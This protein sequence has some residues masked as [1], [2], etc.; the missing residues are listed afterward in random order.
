MKFYFIAVLLCLAFVPTL[1]SAD[2]YAEDFDAVTGGDWSQT[3]FDTFSGSQDGIIGSSVC[4]T[5]PNCVGADG[6]ESYAGLQVEVIQQGLMSAFLRRNNTSGATM[7]FGYSESIGLGNTLMSMYI[8]SGEHLVLVATGV[9]T[10]DLGLTTADE[11][12]SVVLKWRNNGSVYEVQGTILGGSLATTTPWYTTSIDP[13]SIGTSTYAWIRHGSSFGTSGYLDNFFLNTEFEEPEEQTF[14]T[15]DSPVEGG[16]TD[17]R[18][19]D[20]DFTYTLDSRIAGAEE[21][22]YIKFTLCSQFYINEECVTE[23]YPTSFGVDN[24][25]TIEMESEWDGYSL[26][27]ASFWNGVTEDVTCPWWN[28]ICQEEQVLIGPTDTINLN[29]A[30]T[31]IDAD[32]PEW[33]LNGDLCGSL[34]SDIGN[35]FCQALAFLFYPSDIASE[36]MEEIRSIMAQKQPFGFFFLVSERMDELFQ[37]EGSAGSGL[38]IN[39]GEDWGT[40]EVFNYATAREEVIALGV[41]NED[42]ET[43]MHVMIY[44][45]LIGYWWMRLTGRDED[46]GNNTWQRG[47]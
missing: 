13:T 19:F 1:V 30:T 35:G 21:Y 8:D 16:N 20:V 25:G 42:T 6:G 41:Y 22:D 5:L 47:V 12:N 10:V 27:I 15:I 38:T 37:T 29:I 43:V 39:L 40:W 7:G 26:L 4:F 17:S 46:I 9:G 28:F 31:T 18:I 14:I 2:V 36:S 32:V 23:Q 34:D 44:I 33:I 11:W 3:I 24:T 45:M